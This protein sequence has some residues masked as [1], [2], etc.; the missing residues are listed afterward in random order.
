[1]TAVA[2]PFAAAYIRPAAA[3]RLLMTA[4]ICASHASA[5]QRSTMASMFEPLPEMR[6][7]MRFMGGECTSATIDVPPRRRHHEAPRSLR[8]APH[9]SPA[10][11]PLPRRAQELGA[12]AARLHCF[13]FVAD[14]HALTTHYEDREV[15][16]RN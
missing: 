8:H 4:T 6:I 15:I 12:A 14:W 2:I 10:P 3:G 1:M 13:Y 9:R 7:T 16:E 5:A 11:R